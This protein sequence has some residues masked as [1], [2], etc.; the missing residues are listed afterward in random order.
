MEIHEKYMHRCFE[1]AANGLG[2]VAP[3]PMVGSVIVHDNRI[4]GEG[5]HKH[6]GKAHAE[7][8]AVNSVKDKTLLP[9]SI[10]YVS[11]EPCCHFGK[12]PP[13]TDLIIEHKIPH[14]VIG[15]VDPY[16]AVAGKGIS[17]LRNHGI[18]VD[19][20]ILKSKAMHLN[21]R[22]FTFHQKKRPYIILKWAQTADAFIDIERLPGTPALPTWITSEKLRM[23]V[24]KWRT[25]EQAIMVG[26]VT[27]LKD[28]PRLNVRDWTGNSPTRIVLD[29]NLT[30]SN[31]L[32]LFDNS[33]N[34][35]VFNYKANR[36]EGLTEWVN[37]DFADP[38]VLKNILEILYQKGLQSV[39]IE[40]GQKLLTAFIQQGLWDEARIFQGSKF[41]E[42]GL[43]APALPITKF[44][45]EFIGKEILFWVKNPQN[46]Y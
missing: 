25:Q 18:Q 10:I 13:C 29:E 22:F 21:K 16:D 1:L 36:Q 39:I 9:S 30:L 3:N 23:L 15:C 4:I 46:P 31:T 43:R 5:Y 17:K 40:G 8:N 14:V 24:H 28:N 38:D 27:A 19:V 20:G 42:K 44:T 6:Y 34:T 2:K 26:T 32:N 11:L 7:V 12:T 45:Q 41:F 35:L 33:Q 37:V